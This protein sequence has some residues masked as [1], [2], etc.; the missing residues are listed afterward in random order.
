MNIYLQELANEIHSVP[1]RPWAPS[2]ECQAEC[3]SQREPF[4]GDANLLEAFE[5]EVLMC[6]QSLKATN[7][8]YGPMMICTKLSILFLYYR[9]F[10]SNRKARIGIYAGI[11]TTLIN[12]VVGTI[13]AIPLCTPSDP[14]GYSHCSNRLNILAFA[15][16]AINILND[17]YILILPFC[18]VSKL[19]IRMSRKLRVFAVFST[20]LL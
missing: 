14:V 1:L 8:L 12:H 7:L 15:I 11:A 20:G 2:V 4:Q 17:F 16:S 9:L 6:E 19:P 10:S 5:E 13:L 3:L 18:V